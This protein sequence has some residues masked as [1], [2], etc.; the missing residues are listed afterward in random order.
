MMMGGSGAALLGDWRWA[1]G[2]RGSWKQ[3]IDVNAFAMEL[4]KTIIRFAT[5]IF[6]I[7]GRYFKTYAKRSFE[8]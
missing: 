4:F 1:I 8:L 7:K 2:N 6:K 3:K 5:K